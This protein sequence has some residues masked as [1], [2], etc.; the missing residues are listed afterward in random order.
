MT[1]QNVHTLF[2]RLRSQQLGESNEV[3]DSVLNQL[4]Q[5]S[6][7]ATS[8]PPPASKQFLNELI[9][10][11]NLTNVQCA[12]CLEMCIKT[13]HQLPCRHTYHRD[14]IIPWLEIHNTCATCRAE[15]PTDDLEYEAKKR[16]DRDQKIRDDD[17]EEEWDPFYG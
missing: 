15:V 5:E 11:E 16:R 2:N 3:L 13:S 10:L 6:N 9:P 14:C 7:S 17:S 4:F 12:I 8:G 1:A